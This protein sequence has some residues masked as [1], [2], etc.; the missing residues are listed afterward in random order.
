MYHNRSRLEWAISHAIINLTYPDAHTYGLVWLREFMTRE[1]DH[2]QLAV[3][4]RLMAS[5][6]D[7]REAKF[8][9]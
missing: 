9:R 4:T 3:M 6:A 1:A 8:A 5:V 2:Q 7:L